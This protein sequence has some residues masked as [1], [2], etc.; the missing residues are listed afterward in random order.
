MSSRNFYCTNS[1]KIGSKLALKRL[2]GAAIDNSL[3]IFDHLIAGKR[4][5][6][7]SSPDDIL[8]PESRKLAIIAT[9]ILTPEGIHNFIFPLADMI[10]K[11]FH[12]CIVDT[13]ELNFA[14]QNSKV[15]IMKRNNKG[16]DFGS[17]RDALNHFDL[18]NI[19]ELILMNDSCFWNKDSMGKYLD[20][21][22]IELSDLRCITL[23]FQRVPHPQSYFLHISAP[24]IGT[25]RDFFK[26]EVRDWR[27][28]RN[29]VKR[30]EI[31]LG[32]HLNKS[33]FKVV[34]FFG[35]SNSL[36]GSRKQ[37]YLN[38]RF[39]NT[40]ASHPKTIF[41]A[42]GVIKARQKHLIDSCS[43]P[44]FN[45]TPEDKKFFYVA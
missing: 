29:I 18:E 31:Q 1:W 19:D 21:L 16:R 7:Y 34:D 13:G 37:K 27:F 44:K 22:P 11:G 5:S 14:T 15:V 23:S 3:L 6:I 35:G 25:T 42:V 30:G 32:Q 24:L 2:F 12:V 39:T 9:H 38:F 43:D 40:M 41:D 20:N 45:I 10:A 17:F 26:N 28:K 36:Y 33:G 4:S 8:S